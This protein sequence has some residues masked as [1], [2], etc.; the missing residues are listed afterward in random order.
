[1][2]ID[3]APCAL[4]ATSDK[5]GLADFCRR[6]TELGWLLAATSGTRNALMSESIPVISVEDLSSRSEIMDGRIKTL[7]RAIFAGILFR[8]GNLADLSV[9]REEGFQPISMIVTS[10]YPLRPRACSLDELAECIDVGGPAM[11]RAAAKN[12]A[13]VFPLFDPE[14]YRL[15]LG[16]IEADSGYVTHSS[17]HLRKNLAIKAFQYLSGYDRQIARRLAQCAP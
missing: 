3:E 12:F 4:V 1:M 5:S 11:L 8:R 2:S 15:A 17:L 6:L 7:D 16:A 10:P 13:S 9:I 14:D